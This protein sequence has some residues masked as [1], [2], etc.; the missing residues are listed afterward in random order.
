MIAPAAARLKPVSSATRMPAPRSIPSLTEKI[1]TG[2]AAGKLMLHVFAALAGFGRDLIR[3]RTRAGLNAARPRDPRRSE[4]SGERHSR[5]RPPRRAHPRTR[6]HPVQRSRHLRSAGGRAGPARL[7]EVS[8]CL[9]Q[10]R[11]IEQNRLCHR[12]LLLVHLYSSLA[13]RRRLRVPY[14]ESST[15]ACRLSPPDRRGPLHRA[16]YAGGLCGTQVTRVTRGPFRTGVVESGSAIRGRR[17]APSGPSVCRCPPR[18]PMAMRQAQ[19]PAPARQR[20]PPPWLPR[21]PASPPRAGERYRSS[22][23]S[24]RRSTVPGRRSSR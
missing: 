6:R 9:S 23:P 7:L 18:G 10:R 2:S 14:V 17:S 21:R 15:A 1:Q 22:H 13:R 19:A 3:E 12:D 16:D 5:P 4:W 20:R 11:W 24:S 8:Q